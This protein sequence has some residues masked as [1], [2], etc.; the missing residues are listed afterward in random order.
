M[1]HGVHTGQ[2]IFTMPH[3][4]EPSMW[5]K[6]EEGVAA[7]TD[8]S[9]RTV[10]AT[11]PAGAAPSRGIAIVGAS[12]QIKGEIRSREELLVE[13]EVE[14]SLESQSVVTIGPNGKVKANIRAREVAILGSVRGNIEVTEK[15]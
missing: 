15:I 7:R 8:V 4:G 2:F 11:P 14:G 6:R 10:V 3:T 13:G 1:A 5:N 9:P 12:M